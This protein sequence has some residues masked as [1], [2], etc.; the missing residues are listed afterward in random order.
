MAERYNGFGYRARGV[1]SPYV[2][3]GSNLYRVGKYNVDGH[4]VPDLVEHAPGVALL[5]T[6]LAD[7][8]AEWQIPGGA[9][10]APPAPLPVPAG[11]TGHPLH[12]VEWLQDALNTLMHAGLKVDGGYGARTRAAVREYQTLHGLAADGI[13]G[14][15]TLGS[16]QA[17]V[18]KLAQPAAQPVKAALPDTPDA[19]PD[20]CPFR[21]S[22]GRDE[23]TV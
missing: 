2:W 7:C 9:N 4:Y 13:A 21:L 10:G 17:E 19:C 6:V 5:L 11:Y 16:L 18:S 20:Y 12:G 23:P 22:A 3:A 1:H 15:L 8:G 14:P